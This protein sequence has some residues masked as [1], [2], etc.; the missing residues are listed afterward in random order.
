MQPMVPEV[1]DNYLVELA[2]EQHDDPVLQEMEQRALRLNFPIIDRAVGRFVELQA[3][4][5]AARRVFELGSGYGYSAYWFAR[6][7][8]ET[9][10]VICTDLDEENAAEAERLLTH[11]G[12]WDRVTFHVGEAGSLLA[13]TDGEFDV[14]FCDADKEHYGDH[15]RAACERIRVG[16]LWI[17]DNTLWS[18]RAATGEAAPD[19][20]GSTEGIRE[21]NQL[22]A[23]DRRYVSSIVPIRDGVMVALRIA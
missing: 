12:L 15:W 3:R 11:A 19:Y 16:G 6:A 9:G 8:G 17:C 18:G 4:S 23:R 22:V 2:R 21:H 5:I 13:A 20:P 14:I 7:V 1:V 10:E